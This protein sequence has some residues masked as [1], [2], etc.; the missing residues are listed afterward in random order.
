MFLKKILRYT[1]VFLIV[2]QLNLN[3]DTSEIHNKDKKWIIRKIIIKGNVRTRREAILKAIRIREGQV[4]QNGSLKKIKLKIKKMLNNLKFFFNVKISFKTFGD[5][6]DI[7][8]SIKDKWTLFPIPLISYNQKKWMFGLGV[9]EGNFMGTM[10][11]MGLGLLY[12]D[13]HLSG[14]GIFVFR[15]LFTEGLLFSATIL[16]I[17]KTY[18]NYNGTA[19]VSEYGQRKS[20]SILNLDYRLYKKFTASMRINL[21]KNEFD[22]IGSIPEAEWGSLLNISL[23]YEG[24]NYVEDYVYGFRARVSFDTDISIIQSKL[25]RRFISWKIQI[26]LNPLARH[27]LIFVNIGAVGWDLDYGYKFKLGGSV[28]EYAYGIRGYLDSQYKTDRFLNTV[29]EYRVPLWTLSS[30]I[31][32]FV[33][34]LDHALFVDSQDNKT[35]SIFSYGLSLRVY[36]RKVLIPAFVVYMVY[37][38]DNKEWSGGVTLG[39]QI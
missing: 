19:I 38:E 7:Y 34:F 33:P 10:N 26:A 22:G 32:S 23:M 18:Y 39:A 13:D 16:S 9:L 15:D 12:S 14:M 2:F 21:L 5:N 30:F 35:K 4:F 1:L 27:N 36:L 24:L 28:N 11:Q 25:K 3:A 31:V 17:Y 29:T 8:L 20:G 6:V 37:A